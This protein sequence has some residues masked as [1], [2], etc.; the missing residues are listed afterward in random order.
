VHYYFSLWAI[1]HGGLLTES[2]NGHRIGKP[3]VQVARQFIFA[4]A[5]R[6]P[7][8][9]VVDAHTDA[10]WFGNSD[11]RV[12]TMTDR[13]KCFTKQASK[14]RKKPSSRKVDEGL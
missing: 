6:N 7:V 13:K 11:R 1:Q 5:N 12:M 10:N 3:N 4:S 9:G 8:F 14:T 2:F